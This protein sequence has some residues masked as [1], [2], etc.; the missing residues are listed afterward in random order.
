LRWQADRNRAEEIL[1]ACVERRTAQIRQMSEP[2]LETFRQRYHL[3][4]TDT[5][6]KVY[7]HLTENR[8]ELTV[9]FLVQ[10]H[11]IRTLKDV[12]SRDILQELDA[13]GIGIASTRHT[14]VGFPPLRAQA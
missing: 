14:I 4:N 11:G 3:C 7:Y 12:I 8:L 6:P 9:R 2:A 1:L 5:A 10:D 13:T